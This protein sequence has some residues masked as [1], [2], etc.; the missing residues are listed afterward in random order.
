MTKDLAYCSKVE[1]A[2]VKSFILYAQIGISLFRK[3][4]CCFRSEKGALTL[5]LILV[6]LALLKHT[7][8]NLILIKFTLVKFTLAKLTPNKLTLITPEIIKLTQ[9]KLTLIKLENIKLAHVK[10]TLVKLNLHL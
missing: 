9:V 7:L 1:T 3:H 5:D 6:K 8:A 2:K 10:L 4:K